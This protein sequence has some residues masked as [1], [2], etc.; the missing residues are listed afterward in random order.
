M[1]PDLDRRWLNSGGFTQSRADHGL[2]RHAFKPLP[3]RCRGEASDGSLVTERQNRVCLKN[4]P[5]DYEFLKRYHVVQ[6]RNVPE[7][8]VSNR[9]PL[10]TDL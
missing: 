7:P 8:V 3:A 6:F 2:R 9:Q 5:E 10:L 1:N 4:E